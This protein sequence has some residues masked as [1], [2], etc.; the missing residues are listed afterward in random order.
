M[1][2]QDVPRSSSQALPCFEIGV[3]L[4]LTSLIQTL[5]H[6]N[7]AVLGEVKSPGGVYVHCIMSLRDNSD[8]ENCGEYRCPP[9]KWHCKDSGH[10]IDEVRLCDGVKDCANGADEENCS[11]N[12]CPSLGCQAGCHASPHGGECTCPDGYRLDERF[13]RTCS[14][15]TLYRIDPNGPN[16]EPK[17]LAS[18]EFI[19]GVDFDYGDRKVSGIVVDI[20]ARRVY[21]VDPKVDRVESIDYEGN[22]RRI[23]AQTMNIVPHPFGLTL[24]D[25]YLYWTDWTRLGVIKIEKFGSPTEII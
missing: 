6:L 3:I 18:G 11:Q 8:E 25:Q 7:N 20:P 21:W 15:T 12:L 13:H 4:S 14:D 19:Y 1:L 24:F 23:I 2:R 9:G 22:D 17:R 10:C 16:D 5:T